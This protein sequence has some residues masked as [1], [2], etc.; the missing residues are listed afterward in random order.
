MQGQ[1]SAPTDLICKD[2]FLVQSTIVPDGTMD[3][4]VKSS[5]VLAMFFSFGSLPMLMLIK[6]DV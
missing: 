3:E 1:N 6:F 5:M 2:K 4:D